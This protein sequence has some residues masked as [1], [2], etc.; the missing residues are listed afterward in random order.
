MWEILSI[1]PA[2]MNEKH[3][4]LEL[5][6]TEQN[7]VS[8]AFAHPTASFFYKN[9]SCRF[10]FSLYYRGMWLVSHFIGS[11]MKKIMLLITWAEIILNFFLY[12]DYCHY[13]FFCFEQLPH[14]RE[15]D[16]IN[17]WLHKWDKTRAVHIWCIYIR[18]I[19][20]S[21]WGY[22]S[23]PCFHF[24]LYFTILTVALKPNRYWGKRN[25]HQLRM[26]MEQAMTHLILPD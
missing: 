9:K 4:H 18:S 16:P 23:S 10:S 14:S 8:S 17:P 21:L 12:N 11:H 6:S 22:F 7:I 3:S 13:W 1:S 5:E 26:L 19:Y 24:T 2:D 25:L 20:V 15:K